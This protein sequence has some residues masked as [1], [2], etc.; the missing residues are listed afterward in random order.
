MA[1]DIGLVSQHYFEFD[2]QGDHLQGEKKILNPATTHVAKF[3]MSLT[4]GRPR[5][6]STRWQIILRNNKVFS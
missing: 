1:Q 6:K 3:L 4:H 2:F 5:L